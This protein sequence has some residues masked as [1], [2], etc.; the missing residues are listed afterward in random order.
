MNYYDCRRS[1]YHI[2]VVSSVKVLKTIVKVDRNKIIT[3]NDFMWV[4]I[5][6]LKIKRKRRENNFKV[7]QRDA[8]R[9][10]I[11]CARCSR[12]QQHGVRSPH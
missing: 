7:L 3:M 5:P 9:A 10:I 2:H 1:L 6:M 11:L 4:S 8:L 12:Q